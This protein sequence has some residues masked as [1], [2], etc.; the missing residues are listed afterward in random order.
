MQKGN[1]RPV[2]QARRSAIIKILGGTAALLAFAVGGYALSSGSASP[3]GPNESTT[4]TR[5]SSV[6]GGS[7][8]LVQ[9]GSTAGITIRVVYFGMPTGV[10]GTKK[11]TVTLSNPAYLA[12]LKAALVN[13]HPSLKEML[14]T[15]LFLVDG[16][17]AN[18]NPQLQND[19]E[20]DI[21]AQIAGG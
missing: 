12:D 9:W 21:L 19:V 18:G 15:M 8:A 4:T 7:G 13:S 5:S 1:P 20:V 14:P 11:E 17:S 3:K 2:D 16:V 6:S 10:T